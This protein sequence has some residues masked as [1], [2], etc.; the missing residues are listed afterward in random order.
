ML[1]D[2]SNSGRVGGESKGIKG[3]RR[4]LSDVRRG[5]V[6][7][8]TTGVLVVISVGFSDMCVADAETSVAVGQ[9]RS[10]DL[11]LFVQ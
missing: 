2:D 7:T 11:A 5:R 9:E 8:A 3:T 1:V 6:Q 4:C 10:C